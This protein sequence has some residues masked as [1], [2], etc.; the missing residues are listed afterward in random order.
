MGGFLLFSPISILSVARNPSL[1]HLVTG[2]A[3]FV[4]PSP[5]PHS[6]I[7]DN[8]R[9]NPHFVVPQN[10]SRSTHSS[11][12]AT[13]SSSAVIEGI[14]K[15]GRLQLTQRD[16][17]AVGF[18]GVQLLFLYIIGIKNVGHTAP[19]SQTLCGF[20]RNEYWVVVFLPPFS[21]RLTQFSIL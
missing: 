11:Q 9:P 19:L 10:L 5:F 17:D 13:P 1:S 21:F 8:Y 15:L 20:N 7:A 2:C 6:L 18:C 4:P 16:R 14:R 12:R 3:V